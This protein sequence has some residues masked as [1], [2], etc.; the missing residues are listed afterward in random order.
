MFLRSRHAG[1][2]GFLCA[3]HILLLSTHAGCAARLQ[4]HA[5]YF[6][7]HSTFIRFQ[8]QLASADVLKLELQCCCFVDVLFWKHCHVNE[9]GMVQCMRAGD[10]RSTALQLKLAYRWL[11]QA[12]LR[13]QPASSHSTFVF[14]GGG[15]CVQPGQCAHLL[16]TLLQVL[17]R[18]C[19]SDQ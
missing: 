3:Q 17:T 7:A 5:L 11:V 10:Q 13:C 18:A 2:L 6:P 14:V 19:G 8:T 1:W 12:A 4:E 15:V 16:C 9:C